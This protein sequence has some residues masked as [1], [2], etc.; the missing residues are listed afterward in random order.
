MVSPVLQKHRVVG[1]RQELKLIGALHRQLLLGLDVFH[2]PPQR[3]HHIAD[4]KGN[5]QGNQ[6]DHRCGEHRLPP[7][8]PVQLL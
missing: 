4:I 8:K 7:Q 2:K 3:D 6:D 1:L 5:Q